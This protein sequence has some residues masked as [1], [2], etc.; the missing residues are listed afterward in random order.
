LAESTPFEDLLA[1]M[2]RL[3]GPGGCPWDREQT[4]ASLRTYVLEEAHEVIE[5]IESG[6]VQALRE[7]FGD[8]LL[9]VVFLTQICREQGLF[10]M[11]DVARGIRDKL[12]RRHPHVFSGQP[13]GSP[14]EALRRW[15]EIKN[16][17]K[18]GKA[19]AASIL[20]GVPAGQ[21]ALMRALR[22]STKAALAGFD[23]KAADELYA[24]LE[25]ELR[26]FRA[27]AEKGDRQGMEEELGD[28]LFIVANIGRFSRLDPE[29]A[30]HG[31][32]RKF[33]SRFH[34]VERGLRERG[35]P[36]AEASMEQM[37]SLWNEAKAREAAGFAEG[38]GP[39]KAG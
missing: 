6:N 8:L 13:A 16:E 22:L 38:P 12:V 19:P 10:D 25:E 15:E 5:A 39:E 31:A 34:H 27:A 21:P 28:L 14:A 23:W 26:E 11:N 24:K 36:I 17:E 35:I 4:L 3:R 30:L 9:E 7:E 32:S 29:I 18:R 1:V 33:I 37:E 20:D 2:E